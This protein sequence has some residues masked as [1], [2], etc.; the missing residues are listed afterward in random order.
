[1]EGLYKLIDALVE[2]ASKLGE[3]GEQLSY[4]CLPSIKDIGE[5]YMYVMCMIR[6]EE[7]R[8]GISEGD[9]GG[10]SETGSYGYRLPRMSM[11]P[12]S[13]R[14]GN[15]SYRGT[16]GNRSSNG[17]YRHSYGKDENMIIP[18]LEEAMN[19][20]KT[21]QVRNLIAQAID[22]SRMGSN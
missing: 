19:M 8:R 18:R 10:Y 22:Q 12:V 11:P 6:D 2:E 15:G 3:K 5:C 1:M 20:A 14:G 4:G 17:M 7:E 13:Y 21:E 9:M 16:M